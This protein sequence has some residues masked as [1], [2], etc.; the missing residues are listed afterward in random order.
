MMCVFPFSLMMF[1]FFFLLSL[2]YCMMHPILGIS[3]WR[4][5]A[6]VKYGHA[7]LAQNEMCYNLDFQFYTHGRVH[8][9]CEKCETRPFAQAR[10]KQH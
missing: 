4:H 9:L 2:L 8:F 3:I 5:Q 1:I 6:K 10:N 7:S